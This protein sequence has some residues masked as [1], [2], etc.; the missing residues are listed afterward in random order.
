MKIKKKSVYYKMKAFKKLEK[1]I[2]AFAVR[3]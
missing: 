1:I 2:R 3:K